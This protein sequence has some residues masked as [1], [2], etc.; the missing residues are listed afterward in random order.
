V[1]LMTVPIQGSARSPLPD[2]WPLEV[3]PEDQ[4]ERIGASY[5]SHQ[6]GVVL[7]MIRWPRA[8]A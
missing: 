3:S 6:K 1:G 4:L 2:L 8:R 7:R 5:H